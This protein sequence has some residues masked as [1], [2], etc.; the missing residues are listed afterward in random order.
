MRKRAKVFLEE[1]F[2]RAS[3]N[4]Q[5]SACGLDI[6]T[7]FLRSPLP[8]GEKAV[9]MM[10]KDVSSSSEECQPAYMILEQ[11]MNGLRSAA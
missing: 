3:G 11:A 10:P 4:E 5:S 7:A 6:S 1:P 9:V 2:R 8:K